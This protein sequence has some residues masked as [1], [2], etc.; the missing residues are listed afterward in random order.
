MSRR[1]SSWFIWTAVVV[2]GVIH[3]D[4]WFWD[5]RTLVFGFLPV[6][7]AYHALFSLV[8]AAVWWCAVCFAWPTHIEEWADELEGTAPGGEGSAS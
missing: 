3:Q 6:G 4:L 5:D 2:L 7:L 1:A 8:A